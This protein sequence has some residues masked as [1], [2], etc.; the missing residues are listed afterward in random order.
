M[1][2]CD[3]AA[4]SFPKPDQVIDAMVSYMKE[5]GANPGRSGHGPA[6]RA[7]RII[8]DCRKSLCRLFNIDFPERVVFTSNVTEAL[9]IVFNG[10]LKNGDH[11]V[12][13]SVE[14]NSV[15]RPLRH[16]AEIRR[17]ELSVTPCS[18]QGVMDTEALK[19]TIRQDTRLI[20]I[21]H[22]SNVVGTILPIE[23]IGAIKGTARLLVDAAQ[24]A[25]I[26]P[27]DVKK[28]RIDLLA[29]TGH[30]ALY[31]PMGT[32]G[33]YVGKGIDIDPLIRGGTGTQSELEQQPPELPDRLESGTANAPGIAGLG[34]GVE[35]V[36][37]KGIDQIREHENR[38]IQR[39]IEG[40]MTIEGLVLFGPCDHRMQTANLSLNL[41]GVHP[42]E[43]ARV[44]ETEFE[45][46]VRAGLHCSPSAHKTLGTYPDGAVRL[47]MGYFNSQKEV[48]EIIRALEMIVQLIGPSPR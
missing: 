25:G 41:K 32:G 31:G 2:Y 19:R 12:T 6:L 15:M 14:H 7:N 42:A 22:A 30:K 38:L 11:V 35:F 29:F 18:S 10:L 46:M 5:I 48:D 40:L 23:K 43:V 44:L 26:I 17:I 3:N 1:I 13:T 8:N 37:E 36:L 27:I 9:N 4:T 47:S 45:I 21:N 20:V 34:A 28:Q 16:L 24:T 33:L 39:L